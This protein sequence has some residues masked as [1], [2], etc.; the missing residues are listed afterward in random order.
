MATYKFTG[1]ITVTG[2]SSRKEAIE[3]LQIM[4]D[5][6]DDMNS[7]S[8]T[9]VHIHWDKVEKVKEANEVRD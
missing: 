1:T 8:D 7:D 6:F 3:A 9:D 5:D 4:L 2:V